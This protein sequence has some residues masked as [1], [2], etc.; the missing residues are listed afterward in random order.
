MCDK[1]RKLEIDDSSDFQF[2]ID[3]L[4]EENILK[5]FCLFLGRDNCDIYVETTGKT[6]NPN[7]PNNFCGL[8]FNGAHWKGYEN[9][10]MTYNSY[11][12]GGYD[13]QKDQTNNFCQSYA[14]YL[15]ATKGSLTNDIH[16]VELQKGDYVNNV[17]VVS[18]LLLTYLSN[19]SSGKYGSD[20]RQWIES[21][22][23]EGG[24]GIFRLLK[25]LRR[26]CGDRRYA[27]NFTLSKQ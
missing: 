10:K 6:R 25:I 18:Q 20:Y 17:I 1:K 5:E 27:T 8:A 7:L 13:V 22:I 2:L 4:G 15:F 23:D 21:T 9:G 26:L 19:A 24:S 3:A 11:K 12:L 14:C 16:K